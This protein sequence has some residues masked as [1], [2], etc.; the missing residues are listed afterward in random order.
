MRDNIKYKKIKEGAPHERFSAIKTWIRVNIGFIARGLGNN[1]RKVT[2]KCLGKLE[3]TALF[4]YLH[5]LEKNT[6]VKKKKIETVLTC[7]V[8]CLQINEF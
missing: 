6:V 2:N 7:A 5:I 3:Q 1:G 4:R 8:S